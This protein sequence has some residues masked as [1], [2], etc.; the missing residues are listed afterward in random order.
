MMNMLTPTDVSY[1]CM[2]AGLLGW[3]VGAGLYAF[4]RFVYKAYN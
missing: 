2:G 3:L 1:L 4:R